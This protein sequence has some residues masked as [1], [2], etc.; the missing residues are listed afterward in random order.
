MEDIDD[1]RLEKGASAEEVLGKYM[2]VFVYFEV[3]PN[4]KQNMSKVYKGIE[5]YRGQHG[6]HL[7]PSEGFMSFVRPFTAGGTT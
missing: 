4:I 6:L 1:S 7:E 3:R 5:G 2:W